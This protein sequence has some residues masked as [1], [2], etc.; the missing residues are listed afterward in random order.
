M[1]L[2]KFTDF[3]LRVLLFAAAHPAER[4]TIE[5]AADYFDISRAHLKKV[6]LTLTRGGFLR[7]IRGRTGGFELAQTPVQVNLGAVIRLTEPDFGLFEC[8]L[9]G[10]HLHHLA[11]LSTALGRHRGACG[12]S[13]GV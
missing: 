13:V 2:T 4:V 9:T 8:Y 12:V 1:R 5:S 6:V 11:A 10:K 7:G 3:S